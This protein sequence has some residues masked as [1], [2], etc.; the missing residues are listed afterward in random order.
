MDYFG[1]MVN[2]SARICGSAAGGEIMCSA[3]IIR[4]INAKIFE[5][6]AFTDYSDF[7]PPSI[8]EAIR[9]MGVVVIPKG[10]FKL[11]GLEVPEAL[12][13]VYPKELAGREGLEEPMPSPSASASRV[14]FSI[15]QMRQLGLLCLRLEALSSSRIFRQLPQRKASTSKDLPEEQMENSQRPSN[16]MYGDASILLPPI[17]DKL[18][19]AELMTILDSFSIRIENALESLSRLGGRDVPQSQSIISTLQE[20]DKRTLQEVLSILHGQPSS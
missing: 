3:D 6:E 1:P 7:Q 17:H 8:V 15:E 19:D 16:I 10:E 12:S 14:Q 5:T 13:L 2:R 18:S 11:K 20:L 9:G 4:E